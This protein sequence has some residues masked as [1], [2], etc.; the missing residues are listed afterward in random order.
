[1]AIK[2]WQILLGKLNVVDKGGLTVLPKPTDQ[3]LDAFEASS[4]VRLPE[5]YREFIKLFGPGELIWEFRFFAPGYAQQPHADLLTFNT[6]LK[7]G[8]S[9]RF[10]KSL[11]DPDKVRHLVFFCRSS[12]GDLFGWNPNDVRAAK[13]HEYGVYKLGRKNAAE[14]VASS[15]QEFIEST[16]MSKSNLKPPKWNAADLGPR[17]IF[18]PAVELPQRSGG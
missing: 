8:F 6:E 3:S 4:G 1:M 5:S 18:D 17:N 10:L 15:F 14:D 7:A 2:H 16:V 11:K 13:R 9:H 12:T